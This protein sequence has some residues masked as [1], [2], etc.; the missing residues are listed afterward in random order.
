MWFVV[1]V[2]C[3]DARRFLVFLDDKVAPGRPPMHPAQMLFFIVRSTEPYLDVYFARPPMHPAQMLFSI[4]RSTEPYLD[5]YFA[6]ASGIDREL[7]EAGFSTVSCVTAALCCMTMGFQ[8]RGAVCLEVGWGCTF[9]LVVRS[10][11]SGVW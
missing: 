11:G 10:H 9:R 6:E 1:F 7:Q 2:W 8:R 4:M 3:G 5:V